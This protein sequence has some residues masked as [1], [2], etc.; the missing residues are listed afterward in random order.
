MGT[1][2]SAIVLGLIIGVLARFVMPGK[3]DISIV[4]TIVLGILG[5]VVGSWLT[6]LFGYQNSSGG[7][8]WINLIVG[9][10]VACVLIGVYLSMTGRRHRV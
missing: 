2:I 7:I 4:M 1:I 10:L 5:S 3:Q 9:V 6:G 8:A